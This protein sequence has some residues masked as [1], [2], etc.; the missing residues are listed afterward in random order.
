MK[1][2]KLE[3]SGFG[4]FENKIIDLE[5]DFVLIRGDNEAG[6]STCVKFIEGVFYGFVKPYLKTTR[7][8]ADLE[9]YRPWNCSNYEGS[10]IVEYNGEILRVYRNFQTGEYKIYNEKTGKDIT[11]TLDGYKQSN[12]SF[13]GEYFF[14]VSS[15]VFNN[16]KIIGQNNVGIKDEST[17]Y[18]TDTILKNKDD[19]EDLTS[20]KKSVEY[21]KELRRDI[22]TVTNTNK[23]LGQAYEDYK[24]L[25]LEVNRVSEL[26]K[27]YDNSLERL[28][29]LEK[30]F[31]DKNNL[32]ELKEKELA[33]EKQEINSKVLNEKDELLNEISNLNKRKSEIENSKKI[34]EPYL[35]EYEKIKDDEKYLK[36]AFDELSQEKRQVYKKYLDISN[37]LDDTVNNRKKSAKSIKI[38]YFVVFIISIIA[39]Y[40]LRQYTKLSSTNI[41]M[42]FVMLNL[43]CFMIQNR[44]SGKSDDREYEKV[45]RDRDFYLKKID[46][47]DKGIEYLLNDEE[48]KNNSLLEIDRTINDKFN[49]GIK[50]IKDLDEELFSFEKKL[51]DYNSRLDFII[52][53]KPSTNKT[54]LNKIEFSKDFYMVENMNIEE[55]RKEKDLLNNEIIRIKERINILDGEIIKLPSLLDEEKSTAKKIEELENK[56]KIIDLT[57]KLVEESFEELKASFVPKLIKRVNLLLEPIYGDETRFY[58]DE[59][60]NISYRENGSSNLKSSLSLSKGSQDIIFFVLK[61]AIC[62][63]LYDKSDFLI[64]DDA[65]NYLDADRLKKIINVLRE[66]LSENQIIVLSCQDRELEILKSYQDIKIIN[67]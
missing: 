41:F 8:T 11:D 15:E 21:L 2:L 61:I 38:I 20:S 37:V 14:N 40:L 52:K 31:I 39:S 10:I 64:L 3:I 36:K 26:K 57:L 5:E 43:I 47:L 65:F 50:E 30:E 45:K 17:R 46:E 29:D 34:Y 24:T 54:D 16:S 18:I 33:Y 22:G 35:K 42:G 49:I 48:N 55:L 67:L 23:P 32:F 6:K 4:K 9:K 7:Y 60:L 66:K 44:Y 56:L 62:T 58:I 19:Y 63:E 59:F 51:Q 12:K 1:L 28:S 27:E 25:S 13:P 53:T